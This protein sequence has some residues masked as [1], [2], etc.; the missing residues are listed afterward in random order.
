[1]TL[2]MSE[3]KQLVLIASL[4]R[5]DD[6]AGRDADEVIA[7]IYKCKANIERESDGSSTFR[8]GLT[9]IR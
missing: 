2:T 7:L 8:K 1:M 9:V 5:A 6:I 4:L 3:V